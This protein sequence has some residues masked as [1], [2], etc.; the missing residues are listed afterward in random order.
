MQTSQMVKKAVC[1]NM[2]FDVSWGLVFKGF[3]E[4]GW[5]KLFLEM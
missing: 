1:E 3:V 4:I 2:D 5:K